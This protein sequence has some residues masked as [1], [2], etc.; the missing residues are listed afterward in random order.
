[1]GGRI[2]R[3]L[4]DETDD[5]GDQ[6]FIKMLGP[7]GETLSE[8]HRVQPFGFH[9]N[10]PK[11]SHGVGLQFGGGADGGRTLNMALGFE[12]K[13]YRPK[14]RD[15]GSTAIYDQHGSIISLV[16]NEIRMVHAKKQTSVVGGVTLEHTPEGVKITG[17]KVTHN[18]KNIGSD[19]THNGGSVGG[20]STDVPNV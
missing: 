8:V 2:F 3:G 19:H 14:N 7:A 20:G 12:H 18:G 13:Q 6:Q 9:S 17:G 11:G 5:K 4:L 15:V 10:A 16:E 1:M